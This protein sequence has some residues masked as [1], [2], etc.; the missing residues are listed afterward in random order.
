MNVQQHRSWDG[1]S[2]LPC[3]CFV[4][5]E[6]S[7]AVAPG[8]VTADVSAL[9]CSESCRQDIPGTPAW[10]TKACNSKIRTKKARIMLTISK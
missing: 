2:P 10:A 8:F 4:A 6:C 7:L 5:C 9:A 1:E 3:T